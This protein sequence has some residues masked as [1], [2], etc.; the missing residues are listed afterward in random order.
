MDQRDENI[1]LI[2]GDTALST[3]SEATIMQ[4]Q[5][6]ITAL[7]KEIADLKQGLNEATQLR[8][9]ERADNAKTVEDTT[10]GL[11]GVTQ[12][13]KILNEFYEGAFVQYVPPNAGA[14]G[15]TV[16]DMA[17][18]TGFD[19]NYG[20]NQDA[21]S[22]I[23]GMLEVIKSVFERTV[24]TVNQEESDAESA[25]TKYKDETEAD[26]SEKEGLVQTKRGE[27][28][29]TTGV[30]ADS[31]DDLSEHTKLKTM[32]LQ[33]LAKL[34]PACVDTGSDYAEKVARREQEIESLKNAYVILDEMR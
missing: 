29:D 20:G 23:M 4:L 13:L 28:K 27:Q 24:D 6:E 7:L 22:G 19:E 32:S 25:Y 26:I 31:K 5:E 9:T 17:P 11:A 18:D 8:A 2:E 3:K 10:A 30:L 33:E 16:G 15:Q 12:A 14:D 34:K 1:A 21:A